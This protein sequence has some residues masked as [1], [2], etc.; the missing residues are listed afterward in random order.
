MLSDS[1]GIVTREYSVLVRYHPAMDYVVS[2][3]VCVVAAAAEGL[4]AGRQ[5]MAQLKVLKQPSWSPPT[6][7]WILIGL[8]WYGIC[9][10]ALVR[11]LPFWQQQKMPV[12]LLGALMLSNAAANIPAFRMR[13]LDLAFYFFFPYWLLLGAFVWSA[14]LLDRLIC[15]LFAIY[16]VYQLYAMA[17]GYQ[18]WQMNRT[19]K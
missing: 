16:V 7:V 11:L 19:E 14:C 3:V 13:R 2:L 12:I 6:W 9:F 15:T 5:P 17:W 1:W 8:A 10:T 4:C 18:V